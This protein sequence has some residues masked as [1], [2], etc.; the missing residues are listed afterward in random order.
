MSVLNHTFCITLPNFQYKFDG[1][2][3]ALG[4]KGLSWVLREIEDVFGEMC[5]NGYT[6]FPEMEGG[7]KIFE[8]AASLCHGWSAIPCY[9]YNKYLLQK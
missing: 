6:T 2:I 8:D 9:I 5:F 7:E 1:I 4:D 3:K